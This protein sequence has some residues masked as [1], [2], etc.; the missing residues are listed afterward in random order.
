MNK[1]YLLIVAFA[2][3]STAFGQCVADF[4]FGD[5]G[6]GVSPDPQQG[7]NFDSG[8]VN[9]PYID[10]LH[11]LIPA[12]AADVDPTYPPTLPIDSIELRSV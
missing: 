9:Q 3:T 10:I 2:L 12:F 1:F 7:E 6:F 11:I 5:V 4:D 8:V